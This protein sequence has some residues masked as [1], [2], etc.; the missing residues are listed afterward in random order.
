M[1]LIF[2]PIYT[3]LIAS[4]IKVAINR[5]SLDSESPLCGVGKINWDLNDQGSMASTKKTI[6]VSDMNGRIYLITVEEVTK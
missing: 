2:K 5:Q 4:V 1:D 6:N 3:D